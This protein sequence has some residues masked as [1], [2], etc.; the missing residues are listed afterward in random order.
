MARDREQRV[1]TAR[2]LA[3]ELERFLAGQPPEPGRWRQRAASG[4][5]VCLAATVAIVLATGGEPTRPAALA[6][7]PG[8]ISSAP[9]AVTSRGAATLWIAPE[10]PLAYELRL[11]ERE[12]AYDLEFRAGLLISSEPRPERELLGLRAEFSWVSCGMGWDGGPGAA[13]DSRQPDLAHPFAAMRT[14]VA[15][16]F[17][18]TLDPRTGEVV[19]VEGCRELERRVLDQA[20]ADGNRALLD[21]HRMLSRVVDDAFMCLG[22]RTLTWV[23]ESSPIPWHRAAD[24]TLVCDLDRITL[25]SPFVT[26]PPR[27][28]CRGRSHY[29]GGRLVEAELVQTV[30]GAGDPPET[31]WSLRL[32]R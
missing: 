5:G 1:P 3:A 12:G 4:L 23:G 32:V 25:P 29:A 24:G 8:P 22:L 11:H 28:S 18:W 14:L 2:A 7:L 21:D 31:V 17:T 6:P 20:K 27:V 30:P 15:R 19:R 26:Y 13:F 9:A 16:S 10:L